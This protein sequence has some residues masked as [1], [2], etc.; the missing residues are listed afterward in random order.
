MKSQKKELRKA[1]KAKKQAAKTAKLT[2][3]IEEATAEVRTSNAVLQD[4]LD[5]VEKMA[6]PG[7]PVKTVPQAA[8]GIAAERDVLDAEI[9]RLESVAK[10]TQD[11]DIR[12]GSLDR[13]KELKAKR[14][15]L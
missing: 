10:S 8:K 9:I 11:K 15:A 13:L 4:R 7:G 5:K 3:A 6:A 2:K 12:S 14:A 1:E